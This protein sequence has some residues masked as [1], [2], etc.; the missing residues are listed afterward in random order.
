[1][2]TPPPPQCYNEIK[3][4]VLI[5]YRVNSNYYGFYLMYVR[6]H[7]GCIDLFTKHHTMIH[8]DGFLNLE[9]LH[10]SQ[11]TVKSVMIQ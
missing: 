7:R 6:V 9:V 1:M 2:P 3:S 10:C 11:S 8:N 5:A 4:L